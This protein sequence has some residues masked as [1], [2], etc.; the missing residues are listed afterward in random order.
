M[1]G[2]CHI[3]LCPTDK[4]IKYW[5]TSQRPAADIYPLNPIN[6]YLLLPTNTYADYVVT[7]STPTLRHHN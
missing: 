3:Q 6:K 4:L 5:R 1:Y 2:K 7:K